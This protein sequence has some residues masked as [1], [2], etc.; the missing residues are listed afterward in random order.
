MALS[1]EAKRTAFK[2]QAKKN[3]KTWKEARKAKPGE[4]KQ[5]AIEPGRY[6]FDVTG[7]CKVGDKGKLKGH[8]LI[9]IT[10]TKSVTCDGGE[11]GEAITQMYDLS[12]AATESYDPQ[13]RCVQDLKRIMPDQEEAIESAEGPGDLADLID[14]MNENPPKMFC[15]VVDSEKDGKSYKNIRF[16][17][18]VDGAPVDDGEGNDISPDEPEAEDD[19]QVEDE[20]PEEAVEWEPAK[21]EPVSFLNRGK[22]VMGSLLSVNRADQTGRV[23]AD[24]DGRT[25]GPLAWEKLTLEKK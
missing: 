13:A 18:L 25:Y 7:E 8:A 9:E 21:G 2:N 11:E 5:A 3:S 12:R 10:A 14:A 19:V 20:A 17:E 16:E 24:K 4:F 6:E 23:K 22:K 1:A 15:T